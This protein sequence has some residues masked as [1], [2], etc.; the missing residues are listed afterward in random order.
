MNNT[1]NITNG[2]ITFIVMYDISDEYTR[3]TVV[4]YLMREGCLRIQQSVFIGNLPYSRMK[5]IS[6]SLK[7]TKETSDNDDSYIIL[8]LRKESLDAMVF[9]GNRDNIDIVLRRK[10]VVFI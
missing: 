7:E 1:E 6:K 2:D 3:R 10:N 4:T 9:C 8:P 5:E